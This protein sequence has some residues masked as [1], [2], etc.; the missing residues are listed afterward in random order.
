MTYYDAVLF[1]IEQYLLSDVRL[2]GTIFLLN[3]TF[4]RNSPPK[5]IHSICLCRGIN[6]LYAGFRKAKSAGLFVVLN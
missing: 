3:G 4:P 6:N 2:N 5:V 1:K